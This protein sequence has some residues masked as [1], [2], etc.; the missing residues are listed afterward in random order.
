MKIRSILVRLS[1]SFFTL[2]AIAGCSDTREVLGLTNT[3]PDE[4]AVV[5][6]PP[7]SMPP[8]FSLRPPHPG[9]PSRVAGNPGED[10]ARALY[11]AGSMQAVPQQGVTSLKLE[12]LSPSEQVLITQSGSDKADPR[13]RSTIDKESGTTVV[14]NRRL[15][16]YVLFWRDPKK[17]KDNEAVLDP[18]AERARI[19]A[20]RNAGQG[21]TTGATPAIQKNKSVAVP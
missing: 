4:F 17:A 16:D 13:I 12:G 1:L 19:E 7:L 8:D 10:A 15:L 18:A 2:A 21:V 5:D 6:H 3:P 14:A 11:G 9:A 20:A